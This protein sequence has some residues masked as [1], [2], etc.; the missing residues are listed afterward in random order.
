MTDPIEDGEF[1]WAARMHTDESPATVLTQARAR[2]LTIGRRRGLVTLVF[3]VLLLAAVLS[4]A[5]GMRATG[6]DL[7]TDVASPTSVS[8]ATSTGG[9]TGSDPQTSP[10]VTSADQPTS[11]GLP[12]S[13]VAEPRDALGPVAGATTDSQS[14]SAP[15][16]T[17]TPAIA[18]T[19][20]TTAPG[21]ASAA[22]STAAE[23]SDSGSTGPKPA[24]TSAPSGANRGATTAPSDANT[25][26]VTTGAASGV[27]GGPSPSSTGSTSSPSPTSGTAP[28]SSSTSTSA[29]TNPTT[30]TTVERRPVPVAPVVNDGGFRLSDVIATVQ[31]EPVGGVK[32]DLFR[33]GADGKRRAFVASAETDGAGRYSLTG[34]VEPDGGGTACLVLVFIAP[35]GQ[36]FE[37]TGRFREAVVCPRERGAALPVVRLMTGGQ[38]A[39]ASA[40]SVLVG[41]DRWFLRGS[42]SG[43]AAA[44]ALTDRYRQPLGAEQVVRSYRTAAG[45]AD[46][47]TDNRE[48]VSI[49]GLRTRAFGSDQQ[50]T[51]GTSALIEQLATVLKATPGLRLEIVEA[52]DQTLAEP[53]SSQILRARQRAVVLAFEEQGVGI[54]RLDRRTS[55][56]TTDGRVLGGRSINGAL[57][58]NLLWP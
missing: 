7:T 37:E 58:F 56:Q 8:T 34:S 51:A 16:T 12:E 18:D 3:S 50:P 6:N 35:A 24:Q 54:G 14:T 52:T 42:V 19:P 9:S 39:P 10:L 48:R 15:A 43:D 45:P 29:T 13:E 41:G 53:P 20:S 31:G 33:A 49:E 28:A 25:T 40:R 44:T 32:V 27:A 22:P 47:S 23:D 57:E 30:S 21:T 38:P 26:S 4:A 11:L 55:A 17:D 46:A 1:S 36:A 2:G 5:A